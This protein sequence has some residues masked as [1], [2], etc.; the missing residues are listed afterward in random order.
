[1]NYY[2][3]DGYSI[4]IGEEKFLATQILFNPEY[5][6]KDSLSFPDILISSINKVDNQI[7]AKSYEN[8]L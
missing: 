2:L 7:K 3:P 4:L 8:I 1:M 5:I 6:G